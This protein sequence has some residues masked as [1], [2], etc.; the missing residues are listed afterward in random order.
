[1]GPDAVLTSEVHH[2][3]LLQHETTFW[4]GCHMK[5]RITRVQFSNAAG[6]PRRTPQAGL[7]TF[8][9]PSLQW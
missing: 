3:C 5:R 4:L 8:N 9:A 6:V 2:F 1:M 7:Q